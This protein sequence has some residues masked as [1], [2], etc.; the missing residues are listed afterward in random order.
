M[1]SNF[2]V[3]VQSLE[4]RLAHARDAAE[5]LAH[6]LAETHDFIRRYVVLSDDQ[7]VTCSLWVFHTYLIDAAETTPYLEVTSPEKRSGKSRLLDVLQELVWNPW[8][9]VL[10]SEAVTYRKIAD[11]AT[12]LL[13]DEVD[14]IF[15]PKAKEHEGLRAMLNAGYR[16]PRLRGA[17]MRA[18]VHEGEELLDVLRESDR[19]DR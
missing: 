11:G 1:S 12:T 15:G 14:A 3:R 10:P 5:T 13:L 7:A 6:A 8:R 4:E 17:A 18:S 2:D 16:P 19:R 9:A